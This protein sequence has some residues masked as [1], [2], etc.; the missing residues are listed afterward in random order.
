VNATMSRTRPAPHPVFADTSVLIVD[1][2]PDM[3][4]LVRLVL[5][6]AG[7]TVLDE[8]EDGFIALDHYRAQ[9]PPRCPRVV[10]LDNRMPGMSGLDVA[11]AM[12]QAYP[13]QI[14]ILFSAH[15][16][17]ATIEQAREL[18]IAACVAK[19]HLTRL[20]GILRELL[21]TD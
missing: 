16:D 8:A 21:E 9:T 3:R 19:N 5:Q 17:A 11:A 14:V 10:V 2:E 15:L 1:D 13:S 7:V 18:G 4:D 12:L 6:G 20:P